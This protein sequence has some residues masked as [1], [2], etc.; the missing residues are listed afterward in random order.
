MQYGF[1]EEMKNCGSP[2]I[3]RANLSKGPGP[4]STY[5]M[6][7]YRNSPYEQE[8][9]NH[10]IGLLHNKG[11]TVLDVGARDG[12][13]AIMLTNL[14]SSVTALDLDKPHIKH[15]KIRCVKGD[16][17]SCLDFP[18]EFFDVVLCAEVLEH[19]PPNNLIKA[20]L[21][22]IRVA[23][24]YVLVGVPYKQDIRVGR[25][26]CYMCGNRNPPWGHVNAFDEKRLKQL[27]SG[28]EVEKISYV[29]QGDSRTNCVSAFLMDLAGNPYG[30]YNQ[31]EPC[32]H[33]AVK[34]R[35][36]PARNLLQKLLTR[37][38]YYGNVIQN[39]FINPQANWIHVLFVKP[40]L[41]IIDGT[42]TASGGIRVVGS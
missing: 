23:K 7:S 6:T 18:D 32:V 12:Y 24:R 22:L 29:G 34:L 19:I 28:M 39:L 42:Q 38:A 11:D 25:T 13:I 10:L 40:S 31:E 2:L 36:P 33:C 5:D 20:C 26:T 41:P 37:C 8:R 1:K 14:F 21:E 9:I 3:S 4:P 15:D 16:I 27:F 17:T 35:V 30:T